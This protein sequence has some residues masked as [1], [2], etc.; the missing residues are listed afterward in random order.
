M[1]CR[2]A[3]ALLI[4]LVGTTRA[5][6]QE[7]TKKETD[8][9]AA[10]HDEIRALRDGLLDALKNK[11][12]DA[13]LKYL[14][15]DVVL[16]SQDGPEQK[17]IRKHEGVRAYVDRQLTGPKAY[18]KSIQSTVTVDELTILHGD[19]TGIAFGNSKD[20]YVLADGTETDLPT[21]WS[22]TLVKHEGK[23]KVAN[24]HFSTNLFDNP[25][26]DGAK[27]MMYWVGGIAAVV[28]LLIGALVMKLL[29][30]NPGQ[31]TS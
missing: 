3:L 20:H 27:R 21:R 17:V 10:T 8:K 7:P 15:P 12:V 16:T 1:K 26:L 14:H 11:D 19:T 25:V 28:G 6:A 23:W 29:T 4:L 31:V 24:L 30:R 13:L 5:F 2:Q 22:A 9:T 18:I